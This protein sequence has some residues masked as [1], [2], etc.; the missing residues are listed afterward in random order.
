MSG[1]WRNESMIGEIKIIT[2]QN[3]IGLDSEIPTLALAFELCRRPRESR[4]Y[5]DPLKLKGICNRPP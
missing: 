1:D 3:D 5:R 2:K 4:V